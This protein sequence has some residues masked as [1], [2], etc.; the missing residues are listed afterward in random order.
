[1]TLE[2]RVKAG[3]VSQLVF[4]FRTVLR[5]CL[6]NAAGSVTRHKHPAA[7]ALRQAWDDTRVYFSSNNS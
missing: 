5:L 4:A 2:Q 7:E 1:M 3:C 6:A